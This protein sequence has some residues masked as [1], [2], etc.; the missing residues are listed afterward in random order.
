MRLAVPL[1]QRD[2]PSQWLLSSQVDSPANAD[3]QAQIAQEGGIPPLL[4]LLNGLSTNAQVHA[5]EALSNVAR[6]NPANQALIAKAGGISPLLKLLEVKSHE[7]Q[8]QGASALAQLACNN[9]ANQASIAAGCGGLFF[10]T[11]LL[12]ATTNVQRMAAFAIMEVCRAD[13]ANQ[14]DAGERGAINALVDQL[15]DGKSTEAYE[16]VKAE[17]VGALWILSQ[18]HAEN[19]KAIAR[20]GGISQIVSLLASGTPRA[21]VH[22]TE[23]LASIGFDN[24]SNQ[25]EMTKQLVGLL[26]TG[27]PEVKMRGAAL[28]W[29]LVGENPDSQREMANAGSMS[30]LIGLLKDG[31]RSN[32][33]YALWPLSL[34]IHACTRARTHARTHACTHARMHARTHAR[35]HTCRYALW[36]LSLCINE[37]NQKTLLEEEVRGSDGTDAYAC[38]GHAPHTCAPCMRVHSRPMHLHAHVRGRGV[39]ASLA[40]RASEEEHAVTPTRFPRDS[41]TKPTL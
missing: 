39:R 11:A 34:C 1:S 8:E 6:G 3:V 4:N 36:S 16:H 41:L 35:T 20:A 5:A 7:A 10:L 25:V 15:K 27:A 21:Q 23:A 22:A 37:T 9:P 14:T 2:G 13:A 18:D 29:R 40:R 33:K 24:V 19:K 31:N 32:R 12:S 30:D 26:S 28:L 38:A 17:S